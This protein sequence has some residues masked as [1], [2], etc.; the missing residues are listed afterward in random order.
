M[1]IV[2]SMWFRENLEFV[3]RFYQRCINKKIIKFELSSKKNRTWIK[4]LIS[5]KKFLLKF[6]TKNM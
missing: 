5:G 6:R 2:G 3:I 1:K 4:V